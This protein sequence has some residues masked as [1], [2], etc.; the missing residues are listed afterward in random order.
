MITTVLFDMDGLLLDT[1]LYWGESMLKIAAKHG[2]P[3][4][5]EHFKATTGLRIFEVTEY[6]QRNFPWQGASS[7][8]VANEVLDDITAVSIA[9]GN[10]MPGVINLLQQLRAAHYKIGLASSSPM[11]M[12]QP[13]I[14]HFELSPYFDAVCSADAVEYGKPHPA[15]FLYAANQLQAQQHECLVLEDSVLVNAITSSPNNSTKKLLLTGLGLK[16]FNASKSF[17]KY[18][19][20]GKEH[21]TKYNTPVKYG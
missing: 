18:P 14:Q 1:E 9:K 16:F 19:R 17:K 11:R 4:T 20:N 3:I 2:I 13:L 5:R 6:W 12:I 8:Q 21:L 7:E 10:I 15:V